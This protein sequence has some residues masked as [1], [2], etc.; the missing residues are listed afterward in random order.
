MVPRSL[1][2]LVIQMELILSLFLGI[3]MLKLGSISVGTAQLSTLFLYGYSIPSLLTRPHLLITL[4]I[5]YQYSLYSLYSDL[6]IP[7]IELIRSSLILFKLSILFLRF[8]F[9]EFTEPLK[10][11]LSKPSIPI[12]YSKLDSV[13]A[14]KPKQPSPP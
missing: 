6:L 4:S 2:I 9:I 14:K 11:G 13:L 10:F 1:I 5:L 3:Q 8:D 7:P 12:D